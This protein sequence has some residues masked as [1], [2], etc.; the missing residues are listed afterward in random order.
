MANIWRD[1]CSELR[2]RHRHARDA[3][4]RAA[5]RASARGCARLLGERVLRVTVKPFMD[6]NTMIE[7]RLTQCCVH[8][9]TVERRRAATSARR[10]ARCRPGAPCRSNG[11]RRPSACRWPRRS[12][13]V[14]MTGPDPRQVAPPHAEPADAGARA[15]RPVAAVRLRDRRPA[16]LGAGTG[17]RCSGSPCW[18]SSATPGPGAPGCCAPG[19]SSATPGWSC[20]TSPLLAVAAVRR[21]LPVPDTEREAATCRS[22]HRHRRTA[23]RPRSR[24]GATAT[25]A[26][27]RPP[28]VPAGRLPAQPPSGMSNKAKFWIGVRAGAARRSILGR[29]SSRARSTARLGVI[30][31]HERHRSAAI[32]GRHRRAGRCWPG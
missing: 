24:P 1:I 12:Q 23:A 15:L 6:M 7:E 3:G 4:G 20:S 21:H 11:S 17:R 16:G 5:A 31:P 2:P 22:S 27:V 13:G 25:A 14:R 19:A 30:G 18:P 10:S 26:A 8:V 9:A 28:G 29:R 32:L